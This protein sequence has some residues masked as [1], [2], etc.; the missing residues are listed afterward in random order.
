MSIVNDTSFS[1]NKQFKFN[2]NG[3][4]GFE[5][6]IRDNFQTNDSAVF[7]FHTDDKNLM[8]RIYQ[9]IAGYFNDNDADELTNDPVFCAVLG[10]D[11]LASQPTMSRFFNRMNE[12][13]LVQFEK[14]F[15]FISCAGR[16]T[17]SGH[18][19][20]FFWIWILH[21]CRLTAIR[22]GRGS[23]TITGATD[24]IRCYALTA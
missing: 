17:G 22:K 14:I 2:F 16:S 24:I 5:K 3:G 15:F 4:D 21:S 18:R 10:K 1:F 13:S 20:T 19:K 6:V 7:R 12:A 11:A 23:T 8:Q 9:I